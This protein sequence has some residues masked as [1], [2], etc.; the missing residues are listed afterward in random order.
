MSCELTE[1]NIHHVTRVAK[2]DPISSRPKSIV[3]QFNSP[4]IRDT[5]LAASIQY[6]KTN[7]EDKLNSH[8]LGI[9]GKK[10]SIFIAEHLSPTNKMLHAEARNK[11]KNK[12]YKF[13]WVQN[14]KIFVRKSEGSDL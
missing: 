9:S 2:G 11:G 1:N 4:R 6:N 13:V 5:F 3:V 7:P 8:V 12:N 10:E 14:G